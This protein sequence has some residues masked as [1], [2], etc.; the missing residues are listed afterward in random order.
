M[1]D[2]H[3][4]KVNAVYF[5]IIFTFVN[6]SFVIRSI[7]FLFTF[8]SQSLCIKHNS[9]E[10]KRI[11][12]YFISVS[13]H[14]QEMFKPLASLWYS[15]SAVAKLPTTATNILYTLRETANIEALRWP[16]GKKQVT[17]EM[18]ESVNRCIKLGSLMTDGSSLISENSFREPILPQGYE[19]PK[20]IYYADT[21]TAKR[22]KSLNKISCRPVWPAWYK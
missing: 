12:R 3:E 2:R 10:K 19:T 6:D 8:V 21:M 7:A 15:L 13:D 14:A 9:C 5:S 11:F 1:W 16:S 4:L 18:Y 17:T 20:G 22:R